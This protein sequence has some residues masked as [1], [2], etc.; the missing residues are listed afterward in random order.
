M[1]KVE[2]L[3]K[4]FEKRYGKNSEEYKRVVKEINEKAKK[5]GIS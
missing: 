2:R 1:S 3:I 4:A 5:A